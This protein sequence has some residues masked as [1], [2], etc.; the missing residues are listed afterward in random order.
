MTLFT[1]V[2]Q[3][4]LQLKS[5]LQQLSQQEFSMPNEA[6][7]N[8]TIGE[9]TRHIIE[10]FQELLIGYEKGTINYDLRVRNKEIE[11]NLIVAKNNIDTILQSIDKPDIDLAIE[12]NYIANNNTTVTTKSSYYRE[13]AYN[14]EHTVHHLA[15]IRIAL[16]F[17]H[18]DISKEIG[19]ADATLKNKTACAQ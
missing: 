15:I 18:I 17:L 7:L 14:I 9:H 5:I 11:T 13:L 12:N 2:Q 4:L 1:P 19:F 10:L 6:I 16:E 3:V 8:A